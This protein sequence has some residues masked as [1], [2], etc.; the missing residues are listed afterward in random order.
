MLQRYYKDL[1]GS[2]KSLRAIEEAERL[3]GS[4]K[5]RYYAQLVLVFTNDGLVI[6]SDEPMSQGIKVSITCVL[7]NNLNN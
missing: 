7:G 6:Y 3:S 4:L 1:I 5:S 2:K